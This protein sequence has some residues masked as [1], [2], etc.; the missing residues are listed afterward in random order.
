MRKEAGP[1]QVD[2][3]PLMDDSSA[4][5]TVRLRSS[6]R[7]LLALSGSL[8]MLAYGI[9]RLPG[10]DKLFQISGTPIDNSRIHESAAEYRLLVEADRVVPANATVLVRSVAGGVERDTYLHWFGVALL[11]GREVLPAVEARAEYVIV[12]GR[13]SEVANAKLLLATNDGT[14]W[15]RNRP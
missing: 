3:W 6:W 4:A 5:Q 1:G 8:A 7:D 11:P 14:V 10:A 13:G 2:G 15:R 12:L 9:H